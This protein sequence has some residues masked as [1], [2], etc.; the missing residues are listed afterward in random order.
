MSVI[1]LIC[2]LSILVAC[3]G[4]IEED[5]YMDGNLVRQCCDVPSS[6][7]D[8]ESDVQ[9]LGCT[10]S[11]LATIEPQTYSKRI[12]LVT[13]ASA[14]ISTYTQYSLPLNAAYSMA[15]DYEFRILGENTGSNYEPMDPRWNKVQI[16][17]D[18]L[19]GWAADREYVLWIDAD[20]VILNPAFDLEAIILQAPLAD[21]LVC[22]DSEAAEIFSII[23]SGA[24]LVRNTAWSKMFLTSWW[25]ASFTRRAGWDQHVFTRLFTGLETDP[26][27]EIKKHIHLL[28][29]HTMNTRRPATLYHSEH[30]DVLH[31]VGAL[32][33][34]RRLV[35]SEAWNNV[36]ISFHARQFSNIN[37]HEEY[38]AHLLLAQLPKQLGLNMNR[39]IA[40]ERTLLSSRERRA[41]ALVNDLTQI[42][43]TTLPTDATLAGFHEQLHVILRLGD[44]QE[45]SSKDVSMVTQALKHYYKLL[46]RIILAVDMDID[47][48]MDMNMDKHS[49]DKGKKYSA[50][51]LFD[52]TQE[53]VDL[54]FRL[55]LPPAKPFYRRQL[56]ED[57]APLVIRIVNGVTRGF[58]S[59]A[60]A[61]S[62]SGTD[63]ESCSRNDEDED[64]Q[65]PRALY[66]EF[67]RR[68][69]IAQS[70]NVQGE[71]GG[72]GTGAGSAAG[73]VEDREKQRIALEAALQ[74]WQVMVGSDEEAGASI[75]RGS[76]F[77]SHL[78]EGVE[79]LDTLAVLYCIDQQHKRG[80]EYATRGILLVETHWE[81]QNVL[82]LSRSTTNVDINLLLRRSDF[83][84]VPLQTLINLATTYRNMAVCYAESGNSQEAIIYYINAALLRVD[85]L[86]SYD[87]SKQHEEDDQSSKLSDEDDSV[88]SRRAYQQFSLQSQQ[89]AKNEKELYELLS[90]IKSTADAADV[91]VDTYVD[92]A[93]TLKTRVKQWQNK[94][95]K[96][97]EVIHRRKKN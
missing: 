45:G 6:D 38:A 49:I 93:Q 16:L 14:D 41:E 63:E 31:M 23:N 91:Q 69:F 50:S 47:I 2:F 78:E 20:L 52:L 62:I 86:I 44:P 80:I 43:P 94:S 27:H 33:I 58:G 9:L 30:C 12:A 8:N 46:K 89:I 40:V 68:L 13:Y 67:K 34:H 36:C 29:A 74:T 97:G 71:V 25:S 60:S 87:D 10:Q 19:E 77:S 22:K 51:R 70:Y 75:E 55:A 17:K 85:L 48:D 64:E 72:K 90:R 39:L 84:L 24:I 28:E 92:I 82:Q 65:D 21:I 57:I 95:K 37:D 83:Q 15:H 54:A 53:C 56:M 32:N 66:L 7:N 1:L 73:S 35:F 79:V 5:I 61:V 3:Y 4:G 59:S 26:S 18:A 11:V 81:L 96:N 76:E 88:S 42:S